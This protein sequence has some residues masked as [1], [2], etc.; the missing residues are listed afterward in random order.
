MSVSLHYLERCAHE[1]GYQVGTLEKVTRLGEIAA[2]IARHP[3]LGTALALKGGTALNLCMDEAP[4]RMSVDLDYNY[5]GHADRDQMLA[6]RPH[7]ETAVEEIARRSGYRVQRS[8]DEFAGR[9]VFAT[10]QS[11]LGTDARIEV[12]LNFLFRMPLAGMLDTGMWQP[13]ELDRPRVKTVS[14]LELCVGKFFALL[15]RAAPRDAWDVLRLPTIASDVLQSSH[16]RRFFIAMSVIL[17][18]PVQ[19][20]TRQRMKKRM[21]A[22]VIESQ[23]I[24]MLPTAEPPDATELV[25]RAWDVVAPFVELSPAEADYVDAVGNGELKPETLFPDDTELAKIIETHP[26]I[27]WKIENVRKHRRQKR[28]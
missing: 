18:H 4:T 7:M 2:E 14:M 26:A 21:T 10:Y 6:D 16:F 9:K 27:R 12:D 11:V 5:I 3:L 23:L 8:K 19:T 28:H 22:Q 20:Y 1:T 25:D 13:G 17:D 15:D 24:P